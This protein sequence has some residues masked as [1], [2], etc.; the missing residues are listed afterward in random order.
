MRNL[1][2]QLDKPPL[3]SEQFGF[4]VSC[5]VAFT[6][7]GLAKLQ[8]FCKTRL[9]RSAWALPGPLSSRQKRPCTAGVRCWIKFSFCSLPKRSFMWV[10]SR[11]GPLKAF[12]FTLGHCVLTF[13]KPWYIWKWYG[14]TS[15]LLV[16]RYHRRPREV[17]LEKPNS[18]ST[19]PCCLWV[20]RQPSE[21]ASSAKIKKIPRQRMNPVLPAPRQPIA[22]P[23]TAISLCQYAEE[24]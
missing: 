23:H 4:L 2:N 21:T 20:R 3:F 8:V 19:Q 14:Q 16:D 12:R 24:D 13:N 9:R 17:L 11:P 5:S 22:P 1:T 15:G 18:S 6:I 7:I 10:L